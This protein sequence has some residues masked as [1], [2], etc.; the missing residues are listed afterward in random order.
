MPDAGFNDEVRT[1][2]FVDRFRFGGRFDDHESFPHE[3]LT[4]RFWRT[5]KR[6]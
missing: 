3:D 5:Y 6:F 2:I 4:G 1:E